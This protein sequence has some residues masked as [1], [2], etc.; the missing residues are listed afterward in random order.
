MKSM[1]MEGGIE[2]IIGSS[3]VAGPEMIAVDI[4]LMGVVLGVKKL[5]EHHK[6]K[7]AE[8]EVQ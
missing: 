3:M 8:K 2:A 6:A 4:A 5:A 1:L 7:K